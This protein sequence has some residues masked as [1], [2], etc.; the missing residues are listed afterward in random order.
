MSG[1]R[2]SASRAKVLANF[3]AVY[4]IWGST[5]LAIR[6]AIDTI[7]PLLMGCVRFLVA[8]AVL[9]AWVRLRGAPRPTARNWR[10]AAV[11]GG[12][13]LAAGNGAVIMAERTVPS[14]VAALLVAIVP[15]WMV[16]L[17]WLWRGGARPT[18]RTVAGLALGV[19]GTALL[20]G[21]GAFTGR[22]TDPVGAGIL[23]VGSFC[24]AVGSIYSRGAAL[25]S[26]VL[27]G[28]AME[29]LAGGAILG[30]VGSLGG[31][32]SALHPG[33]ISTT[34]LLAV[35]YLIT[36]G[37]LIGFTAY[38]WLLGHVAPARAATYA[39]VNPIVAVV[40]GWLVL[41]EPLT[42]RMVAA[43]AVIVAAVV[44]ITSRAARGARGPADAGPQEV[45]PARSRKR[46]AA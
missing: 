1:G 29:M 7:P 3:A 43:G 17:H 41:H 44:L 24:W 33:A 31:E 16:L 40:L 14:G 38:I 45:A 46:R 34:S 15:L 13:L 5:Y 11:V 20:V 27:L 32:L 8:G 12:L 37:S 6:L 4:L 28:T 19:V 23:L 22:G 35:A 36:F 39:Y 25:P 42:P 2:A 21:R 10:A 9:Y 18:G 30:V 26:N